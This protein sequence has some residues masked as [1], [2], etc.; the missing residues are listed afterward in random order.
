MSIFFIVALGVA[1]FSGIRVAKHDMY[2]TVDAYY[3]RAKLADI[4]AYSTYGVTDDEIRQIQELKEVENARGGYQVDVLSAQDDSARTL[5]IMSMQKDMNELHLEQGRLPRKKGECVADKRLGYKLGDEILIKAGKGRSLEGVLATD[6]L[7]VTGIGD[8]AF[9]IGFG[10]GNTNIGTGLIHGFCAVLDN[11]FSMEVYTEVYVT[12]EG[13]NREISYSNAYEDIVAKGK[14]EI[15]QLTNQLIKDKQ[16]TLPQGIEK[17]LWKVEDRRVFPDYVGFQENAN[18][19]GKIGQVFPVIFFLVAAL[20]SLT[21]MTRLVEEQRIQIGTLMSLG[22]KRRTIAMKFV[23]YALFASVAGSVL[24]VLVGE[25]VF[26]YIIIQAYGMMYQGIDTIRVPY[27]L[28]LALHASLLAIGSIL[29]ATFVSCYKELGATVASLMHP[30]TPKKGKRVVVE[31]ISFIWKRLNFLWKSTIRNLLRYKKRFF[32]TLFGIG[33]CMGLLLTGFGIR[34]SIF[35]ITGIQYQDIQKFQGQ[36]F[37]DESITKEQEEAMKQYLS[38]NGT[39]KEFM[40]TFQKQMKVSKGVNSETIGF[41]VPETTKGLSDYI[42]FRDRKTHQQYKLQNNAVIITE[43]LAK[44][45]AVEKG[46]TITIEQGDKEV[47]V[48]DVCENYFAH[49]VY[50]DADFYQELYKEKP[51]YH[52]IL[53]NTNTQGNKDIEKIGEKIVEKEGVLSIQYAK[54]MRKQMDDMIGSL[55]LVVL[56]LIVSAAFLAFVVLYNLNIVNI[57]ERKREL[58]TLKLLG[59]FDSEVG[60]YVYRENEILTILGSIAGIFFG[61]FLHQYII[62]TLEV[63]MVM[64]GRV[65]HPISFLYSV[66]LTVFFSALVN[67]VMF[68]KL[69]KIDMVSSLKSHE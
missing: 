4:K 26:P 56:V 1:F 3:D 18:R 62:Q 41:I 68:F 42:V 12:L 33:T 10:R 59:F 65:I 58:A 55:N 24:G 38:E 64:F 45:L 6:V 69:R 17:P 27:N 54:S 5:H 34:D 39:I 67:F 15:K 16:K 22:Y 7:T 11:T 63:D 37:Y 49:Y 46:D 9:Y 29:V 32:M 13:A 28:A 52:T 20:V 19:I 57:E 23:G 8:S 53:F 25:K 50:M 48:S 36:I 51:I 47:I 2:N 66:I 14:T 61:L 60:K 43:K 30:P 31:R 35:D 21:T 44:E 40:P